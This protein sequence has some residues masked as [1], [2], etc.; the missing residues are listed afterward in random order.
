V[1]PNVAIA[2]PFLCDKNEARLGQIAMESYGFFIYALGHYSFFGEHE[3]ARTDIWDEFKNH[4]KD[5]A[6]PEGRPLDCVGTPQQIRQRLR[7]FE[8]AGIDQVICLSQAANISH[9]ML[10][11][12]VE[13][14]SK[15]VMPEFK[16]RD[17]KRA[18][19]IEAR[20]QRLTE[21]CMP[22]RPKIAA[23]GAPTVIRAAG[24]H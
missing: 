3:P 23:S 7:D 15:E 16:E 4:P 6:L 10:S 22:R 11:S 24:H 20:R 13:L 12:S 17:Q 2:C 19:L 21:L 9:D 8:E 14:F 5:F 1:N 18:G